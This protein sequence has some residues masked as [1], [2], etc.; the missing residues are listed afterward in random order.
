MKKFTIVALVLALAVPALADKPQK[1]DKG[2]GKDKSGTSV[3]VTVTFGDHDRDEARAYFS[4]KYGRGNCP[5]GL[6]K[7]NNGCLPP[8]Q[9]KKR[10]QVGQPLPR[11]VV[12]VEAPP[13]LVVRLSPAPSG[14]KYVVVDG[15]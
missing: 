12:Y 2:K 1:Q 5:P 3:Q 15:D 9:A 7:K 13:D 6:A 11:G 4:Q 14:Y 10:Y 8:G